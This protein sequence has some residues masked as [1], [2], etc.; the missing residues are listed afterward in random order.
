MDNQD[1][2]EIY[3]PVPSTGVA[4]PPQVSQTHQ[5]QPVATSKPSKSNKKLIISLVVVIVILV[6]TSVTLAVLLLGQTA[7]TP[8]DTKSV[9]SVDESSTNND[10]QKKVCAIFEKLCLAVPENWQTEVKQGKYP[11]VGSAMA[12]GKTADELADVDTVTITS[13]DGELTVYLQT[14]ISGVGGRCDIES[15]GKTYVIKD[16]PTSLSGYADSATN[17]QDRAHALAIITTS[18][19]QTGF[20]PSITLTANDNLIGKTEEHYC[21]S[22]FADL[23][24]DRN[25]ILS[26]GTNLTN[27]GLLSL[28]TT[29]RYSESATI[30]PLS[31]SSL[32]EAKRALDS[33]N[34]QEALEIVA[35]AHY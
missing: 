6:I 16:K 33:Q 11:A 19:G 14:G 25:V 1:N 32:D 4:Q 30:S 29:S 12:E 5:N 34:F 20:S 3:N 10:K 21:A 17:K 24:N 26:Q 18:D 35:S 7:I 15:A 2:N 23:L 13:P 22:V 9:A 8:N 31:F 27:R 28:S